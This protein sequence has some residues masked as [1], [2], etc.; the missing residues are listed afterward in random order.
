MDAS[1]IS[2]EVAFFMALI[3]PLLFWGWRI[4]GKLDSVLQLSKDLMKLHLDSNS[5]FSNVKT[6]ELLEKQ[7]RETVQLL[8]DLVHYTVAGFEA[9]TGKKLKPP[10]PQ[11]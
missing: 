8:R 3:I 7:G 10:K 9:E 2:L 1:E 6:N 5:L 11:I 4:K